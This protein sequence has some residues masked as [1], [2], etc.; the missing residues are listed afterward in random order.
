[1][2]FEPDLALIKRLGLDLEQP[3]P[4]CC[5]M[6]GSFGYEQGERYE[7]SVKVGE[8]VLAPAVRAASDDTLIVADGF[9]C[10]QQ[11]NALTGRS[12]MHLAEVIRLA[13]REGPADGALRRSQPGAASPGHMLFGD[14]AHRA[15]GLWGE[16]PT[17]HEAK[18]ENR[19]RFVAISITGAAVYPCRSRVV[20]AAVRRL[21]G[22]GSAAA[23]PDLDPRAV[24]AQVAARGGRYRTRVSVPTPSGPA[25]SSA[26]VGRQCRDRCRAQSRTATRAACAGVAAGT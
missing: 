6:A 26:A 4:G 22:L 18:R 19:P 12:A 16:G 10:R 5:G 23:T 2:G 21:G 1:M 7:L 14:C 17:Q 20:A 11:I 8:R 24:G 3:D 25:A 13:L 9:S 15:P